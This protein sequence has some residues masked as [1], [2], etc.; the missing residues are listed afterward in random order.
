[1]RREGDGIEIEQWIRDHDGAT[2]IDVGDDGP[3]GPA[4]R[5]PA[6]PPPAPSRGGC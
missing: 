4:E 6:P 2:W 5:V 3:K 1:M